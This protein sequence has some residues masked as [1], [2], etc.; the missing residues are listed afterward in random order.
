M[1]VSSSEKLVSIGLDVRCLRR[2]TFIFEE[3]GA[4]QNIGIYSD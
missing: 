1:E 4:A 2:G 3:F